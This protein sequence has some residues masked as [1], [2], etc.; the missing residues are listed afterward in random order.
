MAADETAVLARAAPS[1][2]ARARYG[3]L[4]DTTTTTTTTAVAAAAA[5]TATG[6][7]E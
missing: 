3:T 2:G 1:D 5:A 6:R 7:R 4:H